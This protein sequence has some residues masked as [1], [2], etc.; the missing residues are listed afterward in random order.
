[1][2]K[3]VPLRIYNARNAT[4]KANQSHHG[5]SLFVIFYLAWA[6]TIGK[7]KKRYIQAFL[8]HTRHLERKRIISLLY[9]YLVRPLLILDFP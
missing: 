8:T 4:Q 7:L 1:M 2:L 9:Y 3:V 6:S 5:A